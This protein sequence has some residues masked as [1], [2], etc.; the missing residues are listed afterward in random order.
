MAGVPT[1]KLSERAC[2][3]ALQRK[4]RPSNAVASTANGD[5]PLAAVQLPLS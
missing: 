2:L 1:S 3:T 4:E 5:D